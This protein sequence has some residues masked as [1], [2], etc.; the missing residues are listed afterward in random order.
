V[1]C[2]FTHRTI[3]QSLFEKAQGFSPFQIQ[4]NLL[5]ERS[6]SVGKWATPSRHYSRVRSGSSLKKP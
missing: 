3:E 2:I 4:P 6:Q 1:A 5:V